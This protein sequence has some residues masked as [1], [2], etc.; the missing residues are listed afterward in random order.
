MRPEKDDW[1]S[2]WKSHTARCSEPPLAS[3]ERCLVTGKAKRR[4]SGNRVEMLLSFEILQSLKGR[5]SLS[6]RKATSQQ[7]LSESVVAL[8]ESEG[9]SCFT[10]T[11]QSTGESL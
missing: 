1:F 9:Q 10:M 6:M 2:G 5:R 3:L 11:S 7:T 8:A 4:Q